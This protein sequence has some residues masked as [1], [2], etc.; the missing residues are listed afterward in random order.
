MKQYALPIAHVRIRSTDNQTQR[1]SI[2]PR[3]H[4]KRYTQN[5]MATNTPVITRRRPSLIR[6]GECIY[7]IHLYDQMARYWKTWQELWY[8][9][10]NAA[11]IDDVT[12]CTFWR[13][14]STWLPLTFSRTWPHSQQGSEC[15]PRSLYWPIRWPHSG[16]MTSWPTW[17]PVM[18]WRRDGRGVRCH[19]VHSE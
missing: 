15:G 7:L 13:R 2:S 18:Y 11:M 8:V 3:N 19:V 14:R 9:H 6:D 5:I 16:L 1:S 12:D 10:D 17:S 4:N